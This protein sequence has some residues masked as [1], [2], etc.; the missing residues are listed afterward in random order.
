MTR[1]AAAITKLDGLLQRQRTALLNGDIAGFSGLG[2]EF[3]AAL[4]A[5]SAFP[6]PPEQMTRLRQAAA[7]VAALNRAGQ[8]GLAAAQAMLTR[9]TDTTLTTY[10]QQ[11]RQFA[12]QTDRGRV[13]S[14]R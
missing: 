11:G 8:R 12:A 9:Q 2:R 10:T 14:R 4:R 1:S 7:E 6:P 13:L 3:E 5:L